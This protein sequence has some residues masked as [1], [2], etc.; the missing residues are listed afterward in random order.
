M[1][2]QFHFVSIDILTSHPE[3]IHLGLSLYK[4]AHCHQESDLML[5][6]PSRTDKVTRLALL[7]TRI[8]LKLL[9]Y[10]SGRSSDKPRDSKTH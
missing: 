8:S 4:E 1:E 7:A 9:T 6:G 3:V 10:V 5:G 2:T